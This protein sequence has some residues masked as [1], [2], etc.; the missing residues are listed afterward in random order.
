MPQIN[1][2]EAKEFLNNITNKDKVAIIHHNDGDGYASGIIFYDWCKQKGAEVENFLFTY[3]RGI[4]IPKL[5]KFNKII[6]TD[7]APTGIE[8]LQL[9][10]EKEIFYTDH[11]PSEV[12]IP[13]KIL[14]YRTTEEGYIPSARTAGELTGIKKWLSIL[15][16]VTDAG[17]LYPEN[18]KFIKELL[19]KEKISIR[20]FRE[21]YSNLFTNTLIYFHNEQQKAFNIIKEIKS[22]EEFKKLD[23]YSEAV[24]NELGRIVDEYEEK[25]EKLGDINFFYFETKF[26]IKKALSAIISRNNPE[27]IIIFATP[28]DNKYLSISA[29][30]QS[31]KVDMAELLRIGINGLENTGAGGHKAASGATIQTK[32]LEQFKE[33]IRAF[34]EQKSK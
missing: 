18:E 9:P 22:L 10:L 30:N 26:Y 32:D 16:T 1:F 24:E 20:E 29:R 23:K 3:R 28:Q 7:I 2:N 6:I 13:E 11:H 33:N 25:K 21:K 19:E 34:T 17:D 31:R 5:D 15:G 4:K 8:E 27:E 12:P 14:E